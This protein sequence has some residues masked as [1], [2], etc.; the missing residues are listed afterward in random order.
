MI[1]HH[2]PLVLGVFVMSAVALVVACAFPEPTLVPD[3]AGAGTDVSAES[4]TVTPLVD[5]SD[6]RAAIGANEDVDPTGA[7]QDATTIPDG[8]GRLDAGADAACCDCDGDGFMTDGGACA[9]PTGDCDDQH[10]YVKPGQGFV[11][12]TIWDTPHTP[13]YDWDCNGQTVKQYAYGVGKCSD[14]AKLEGCGNFQNAFEGNPACGETG[15]YVV[16][17]AAEGLGLACTE[18]AGD[19]RVQGCR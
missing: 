7:E 6:D 1:R 10:P 18:T 5:A 2:L 11:A 15:H 9:K 16:T 4:A 14:H 3:D 19:D 12:S 13:T 17:C 8:G